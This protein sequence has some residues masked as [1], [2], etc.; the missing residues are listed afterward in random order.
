MALAA[1]QTLSYYRILAPLGSGGMGEVW[2]AR[3]TRLEREVAIKVLPSDLAQGD[4]LLRF[5][6][7]ART[8]A[9]LNHPNVAQVY[10]FEC[11]GE[12]CFIAMELVPG[13]DLAERLA[14]GPLRPE[15]VLDVGRQ[16]AAGLEA[17][18]EAG[19]VHRDLKPANVR[20]TPGGDVKVLDFG[21]AKGAAPE[22]RDP[23][24]GDFST[25]EGR[26]LGTPTY[27]APEQ[28]RGR[29]VDRRV[30]V[31]A[32]GCVLYECLTGRRAF[33]GPTVSDVLAAVLD[34]EPDLAAL[35]SATPPRLRALIERCLRKDPRRRLRDVGD[36]RLELEELLAGEPAP[37]PGAE[38]VGRRLLLGLVLVLG[39][40]CVLLGLRLLASGAKSAPLTGRYTLA[41]SPGVVLDSPTG[42]A[43][44]LAVSPDGRR[45]AFAA[46]DASGVRRLYLREADEPEARALAG[47]EGGE[48]PFFSPDGEQ[49]GFALDGA[50]GL[51]RI[52]LARDEVLPIWFEGSV[53]VRGA[54]W[55]PDDSLILGQFDQ[56]LL[57]VPVAGG[58]VTRLTTPGPGESDHRWPQVL[59]DGS[60]LYTACL[61]DGRREARLRTP[62]GTSVPLG[63]HG[64]VAR[65]V[66]PGFLV[67]VRSG[68]VQA[69]R[70]DLAARRVRGDPRDVLLGIEVSALGN[71]YVALALDGSALVYE[72]Q[73]PP[74]A[75]REL[76]WVDRQG[77][78][79]PLASGKGFEFPRLSPD[80]TRVAAAIHSPS[81]THDVWTFDVGSGLE[82]RIT[83]LGTCLQP[84]WTHGGRQIAF[85]SAADGDLYTQSLSGDLPPQRL[86]EREGQQFPSA[87]TPQGKLLFHEQTRARH[88]DLLE[89]DPASG[90]VRGLATGDPYEA[91]GT[92]SPDGRWLAYLSDETGALEVYLRS[93]PELGPKQR[94]TPGGGTEP[95]WSAAGDE[96]YFRRGHGLHAVRLSGDPAHPVAE[97]SLL[98]EGDFVAGFYGRPNYD[99]AA[100]GRRFVMV[101][102]DLGL[103]WGVL[104]LDLG[105]ASRLA[106]LLPE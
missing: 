85:A 103:S 45:V 60:V 42:L 56:G 78:T 13:E 76:V 90:E 27:M 64:D 49:L 104:Q 100:D 92:V 84:A 89:L 102:Q 11:E 36:A 5:Q 62:D 7:E 80:G 88:M 97:T 67:L 79:T 2:R 38:P 75:G 72:P 28:V 39:L 21:L 48:I 18:H 73:R 46:V 69:V 14:R 43:P 47:T 25:E 4:A 63:V 70:L 19:V 1:G 51:R 55:A 50:G 29:V 23:R 9:A 105:F 16:I 58:A 31:W 82:T 93:Y 96:L 35:P 66:P 68:A 17:A 101:E 30:D 40:T 33:D 26:V 81:S 12:T 37:V 52:V 59:P 32:F 98:F 71:P 61:D 87:W 106:A 83:T 8:L 22:A 95:V 34:R 41:L 10:G 94:V 53:A 3:D 24:S 77:R 54:C 44:P 86:L 91:C 99:V 6:R 15:A 20:R 57:R 65:Y 74:A